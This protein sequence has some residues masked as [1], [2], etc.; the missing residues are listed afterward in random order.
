MTK[1]QI[2]F[3]K[4]LKKY[5][6]L[7]PPEVCKKLEIKKSTDYSTD[8]SELVTYIQWPGYDDEFDTFINVKLYDDDMETSKK[9]EFSLT[10]EGTKYLKSLA[11][12]KMNVFTII[13]VVIGLI[14]AFIA[15]L[16]QFL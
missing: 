1:N 8:Y 6:M 7:T 16:P 2:K 3:L 14:L 12:S 5:G 15:V 4:I 11:P 13:T 9:S 10:N